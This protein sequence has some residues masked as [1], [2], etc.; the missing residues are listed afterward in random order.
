MKNV[1]TD[2]SG[3]LKYEVFFELLDL[4]KVNLKND[5]SKYLKKHY[6]KN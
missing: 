6:S 3:F 5:A 2:K 4:H 1:D